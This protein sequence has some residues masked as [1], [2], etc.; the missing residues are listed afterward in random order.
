M[1]FYEKTRLK[2]HGVSTKRMMVLDGSAAWAETISAA[3]NA[4]GAD[5]TLK[6]EYADEISIRRSIADPN[7]IPICGNSDLDR[8]RRS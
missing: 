8:P 6:R 7:T 1:R 3:V 4:F 5:F 2:P